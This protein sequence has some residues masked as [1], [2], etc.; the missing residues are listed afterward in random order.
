VWVPWHLPLFWV[1][2]SF[3]SFGPAGADLAAPLLSAAVIA[4]AIVLL[5]HARIEG[6]GEAGQT[7]DAAT[8]SSVRQ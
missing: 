1:S 2:E 8:P 4:A 3:Q 6:G 7:A 5:R